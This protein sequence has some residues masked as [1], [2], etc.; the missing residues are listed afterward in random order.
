[1]ERGRQ[2]TDSGGLGEWT[3][4][5]LYFEREEMSLITTWSNLCVLNEYS[6]LCTYNGLQEKW[7]R[8]PAS[9]WAV[10][11]S[12]SLLFFCCGKTLARNSLEEG[13]ILSHS[14][15]SITWGSQGWKSRQKITTENCRGAVLLGL[16]P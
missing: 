5:L 10:T 3:K 2:K 13:K 14:L 9:R 11:N 7:V 4:N 12:S 1:M 15:Q 8:R 6:G 16:P